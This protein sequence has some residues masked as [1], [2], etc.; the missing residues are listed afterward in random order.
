VQRVHQHTAV[1]PPALTSIEEICSSTKRVSKRRAELV[2]LPPEAQ[3]N[4]LPGSRSQTSSKARQYLSRASRPTSSPSTIDDLVIGRGRVKNACVEK[5]EYRDA[6]VRVAVSAENA[7][8]C[9]RSPPTR[10]LVVGRVRVKGNDVGMNERQW[11]FVRAVAGAGCAPG[12]PRSS[13]ALND[14][15]MMRRLVVGPVSVRGN[16]NRKNESLLTF[17]HPVAGANG[18]PACCRPSR[19]LKSVE[20]IYSSTKKC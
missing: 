1:P 16:D 2:T 5:N 19:M 10:K 20:E 11:T 7:L 8:A 18:A 17:V 9:Y 3:V 13:R 4:H 15:E 14:V 12:G 6:S